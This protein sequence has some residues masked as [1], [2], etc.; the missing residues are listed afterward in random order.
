MAISNESVQQFQDTFLKFLQKLNCF[1][2]KELQGLWAICATI[3]GS[4][5]FSLSI[6]EKNYG[7]EMGRNFFSKILQKYAAVQKQTLQAYVNE[8][9]QTFAPRQKDTR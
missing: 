9:C 4:P 6:V 3:I 2:R 5:A 8:I 1:T 7:K